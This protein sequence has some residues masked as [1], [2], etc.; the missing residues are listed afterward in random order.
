[1]ST[2]MSDGSKDPKF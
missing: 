2:A 1:M